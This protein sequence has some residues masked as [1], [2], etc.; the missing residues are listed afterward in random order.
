MSSMRPLQGKRIRK[1]KENVAM[2]LDVYNENLS[3][4]GKHP[5]SAELA[6]LFRAIF[7]VEVIAS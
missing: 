6:L 4:D 5:L 3:W 2:V 1:K 7:S